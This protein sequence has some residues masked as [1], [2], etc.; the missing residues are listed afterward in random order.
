MKII[1]E[2]AYN[3]PELDAAGML[4]LLQVYDIPGLCIREIADIL[5][6]DHKFAQQKIAQL[7][8]GRKKHYRK[9]AA[10]GRARRRTRKAAAYN[11]IDTDY[12]L[13]DKRKRSLAVTDAGAALAELI[14]PLTGPYNGQQ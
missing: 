5:Q 14:K 6:I 1:D 11:L 7:A 3:Y 9:T 8:G 2:I 12:N 4:I 10:A 13:G